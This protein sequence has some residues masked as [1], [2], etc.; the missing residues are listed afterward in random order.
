MA[1]GCF[2]AG[3]YEGRLLRTQQ[4]MGEQGVSHLLV[5]DPANI[6]Y[7]TGFDACSFYVP[8]ALLVTPG[9]PISFFCR[10]VDAPS[11]WLTA[12]L[13]ESQ[14]FG[15]PERYVQQPDI[16]P[17][18]W[19]AAAVRPQLD[20]LSVLAVEGDSPYHTVR[21]HLALVRGLGPEVTVHEVAS[22]VSR[23]RALK[24]PAELDVMRVAG[25]IT[26]SV[27]AVARDV[28]RPGVRQC[29]AVAEMYAAQIRGVGGAAGGYSA[30]PPLVLAGANTAFPHVPWSD[31]PFSDTEPVAME[32]AGC[33]HRYHVPVART[34]ILGRPPREL[35]KL[36]EIVDHGLD[37]A[38]STIRA[39]VA[40]EDVAAAWDAV[41]AEHGLAKSGRIGY[42]VGIG[43]PPDWGEQTMSLRAGDKTPLEA[44][45]TFHV[46]I[47]MWL[48][49]WGYS[50]SETVVVTD[51]GLEFLASVP[52]GLLAGR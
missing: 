3:E 40:C 42:P 30:I 49:G 21:S 7:L 5:T 29:D 33:R 1:S 43:F 16:H 15:Y 41:I 17:M 19:V 9:K 48:E 23:V 31:E 38:L 45:M 11:A 25:R 8:Q 24:S 50:I 26:E 47:G 52:R 27:F 6:C 20:A 44:G 10:E 14:V 46:M 28:V 2:S 22:T 36:S 32:L 12:H 37:A 13:D 35:V 18:D 39:G 34:V 51:S 4:R